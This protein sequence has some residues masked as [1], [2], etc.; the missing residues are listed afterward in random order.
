M[1]RTAAI[2]ILVALVSMLGVSDARAGAALVPAG[3]TVGAGLTATIVIDVTQGSSDKGLTAIRVQKAAASSAVIF[4]SGYVGSIN[5][6]PG[7]CNSNGYFDVTSS[8]V[9]RFQGWY[10]DGII[11]NPQALSSLL[12]AFGNPSKATITNIDYVACTSSDG[13]AKWVLSFSAVIGFT[14]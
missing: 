10:I 7:S 5:F 11:D 13:G 14:K 4:D 9:A 1:K 6:Q 12:G 8:T 3:K 2:L